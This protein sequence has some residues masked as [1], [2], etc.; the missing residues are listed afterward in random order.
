GRTDITNPGY[1]FNRDLHGSVFVL[2]GQGG[3]A[4]T[5]AL[6]TAVNN[7]VSAVAA[8]DFNGDGSLDVVASLFYN[9]YHSAGNQ[10]ITQDAQLDVFLNH[11]GFSTTPS[12]TVPLGNKEISGL[13]A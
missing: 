13:A 1:S 4:P 7:A 5:V 10:K 3:H 8:G 2:L 12:S 11:S 9:Y 6:Q